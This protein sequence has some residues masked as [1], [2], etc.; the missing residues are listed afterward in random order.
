M[1][2]FSCGLSASSR[3]IA[4][5]TNSAGDASPSLTSRACSVASMAE[6]YPGLAGGGKG[7]GRR[8]GGGAGAPPPVVRRLRLDRRPGH[9]VGHP[10]LVRRVVVGVGDVGQTGGRIDR[11]GD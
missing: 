2:A 11:L 5:S 3:S 4:A 6:A 1:T 7:S 10:E 8:A 9:L